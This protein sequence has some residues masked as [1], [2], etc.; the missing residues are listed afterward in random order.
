MDTDEVPNNSSAMDTDGVPNNL[1]SSG[2]Q[3]GAPTEPMETDK[4]NCSL[5]IPR[6]VS[7]IP[8]VVPADP[9]FQYDISTKV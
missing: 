4:V 5:V 8:C 7:F 3:S 9:L 2:S 6:Y 1:S